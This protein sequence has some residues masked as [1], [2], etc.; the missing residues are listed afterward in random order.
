ME[1]IQIRKNFDNSSIQCM[2]EWIDGAKKMTKRT[3]K[4]PISD[5]RRFMQ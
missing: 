3:T 5:T 4:Y 2:K 1:N